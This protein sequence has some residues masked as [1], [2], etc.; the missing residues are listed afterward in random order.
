MKSAPIFVFNDETS[1][2]VNEVPI[3]GT[4]VVVNYFDDGAKLVT[5][6]SND[7]ITN[8]TTVGEFLEI[9]ETHWV[10]LGGGG[11]LE[12]LEENNIKGWRLLKRNEDHYGNIGKEAID[13]SITDGGYATSG[14]TGER[15]FATGYNTHSMG[16]FSFGEGLTTVAEVTLITGPIGG[17]GI[18]GGELP[19]GAYNIYGMP[20]G[21]VIYYG[22][23]E[24]SVIYYGMPEGSVVY[25]G[26]PESAIA[27]HGVPEGQLP[28]FTI[29][30][31]VV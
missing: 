7:G 28:D 15:S 13:L 26:L 16:N 14:A 9:E 23:P 21:S 1:I 30:G 4:I 17:G 24:G 25:H 5:K 27:F 8:T 29:Y 18:P 12:L 6:L 19:E 22:M 2:L 31:E 3:H 11:E 10:E 20:E